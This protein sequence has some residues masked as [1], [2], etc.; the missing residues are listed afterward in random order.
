MPEMTTTRLP[1]T[2]YYLTIRRARNSE[3]QREWENNTNKLHFIKR[4]S[5]NGKVHTIAVGNTRTFDFKK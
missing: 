5:K 1:Y 3:W 4:E 2:H